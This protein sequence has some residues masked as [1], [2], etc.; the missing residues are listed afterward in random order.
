MEMIWQLRHVADPRQKIMKSHLKLDFR[1]NLLLFFLNI[2]C[3]S[4]E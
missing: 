4:R 3:Q 2:L 1:N